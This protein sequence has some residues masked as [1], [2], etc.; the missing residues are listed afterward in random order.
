M[1]IKSLIES[2]SPVQV[3]VNVMDLKE[4]ALTMANEIKN[5]HEASTTPEKYLSVDDT[6]AKIGV[7]K[8]TL[9]RWNKSHYLCPV[10]VGHKSLYKCSDV[11][12]LLKG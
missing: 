3:V 10:K 2:G 8:N 4:F 12:T 6:A 7:T 1:N 9:W 5:S 11:E